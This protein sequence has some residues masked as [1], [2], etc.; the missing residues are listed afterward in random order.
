MKTFIQPTEKWAFSSFLLAEYFFLCHTLYSVSSV[1][2]PEDLM[3]YFLKQT[4]LKNRT[5]LSIVESFYNPRKKGA[6]HRVFKSLTSI[7][8]LR[9]SG[10]ED[11]VA[12]YQAEVDEL[13][14]ERAK[15]KQ[16]LISEQSPKRHLGYF[17]V[18]GIL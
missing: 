12:Y 9:Q 13:N 4:K 15:E 16:T 6:A 17:P 11:P 5:Y 10:M 14:K 3:A 7:E 2:Q 1:I 8:S 18:K